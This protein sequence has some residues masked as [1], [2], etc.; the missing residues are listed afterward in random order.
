MT[1]SMVNGFDFMPDGAEA[2]FYTGS[3]PEHSCNPN[4]KMH[5]VSVQH[6]LPP[7]N[8]VQAVAPG[9]WVGEWRASRDIA[10]GEPVC[11]SYLEDDVLARGCAERR[12]R[13]LRRMGFWCLCARCH[14]EEQS[15][16][17]APPPKTLGGHASPAPVAGAREGGR[18]R[19]ADVGSGG[20]GGAA[21]GISWA[22]PSL[23]RQLFV[24]A[25][26]AAS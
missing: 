11:C 23:A 17:A 19:G 10:E 1:C 4:V 7:V 13:L 21:A 9:T 12:A 22:E 5:I 16:S 15:P 14:T 8:G 2:I 3:L 24:L 6:K 20:G 18:R 26:A 25:S